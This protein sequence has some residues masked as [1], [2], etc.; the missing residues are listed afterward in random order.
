MSDECVS[1][2]DEVRQVQGGEVDARGQ[3][4]FQSMGGEVE[5]VRE[6]QS[7]ERGA[8]RCLHIHRI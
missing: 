4:G 6:V 7:V 1:D 8:E 2:R 3:E 5:T